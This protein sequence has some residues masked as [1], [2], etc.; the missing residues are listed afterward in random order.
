MDQFKRL[1]DG[2]WSSD[3]AKRAQAVANFGQELNSRDD[4]NALPD[5][6]TVCTDFVRK[7]HNARGAPMFTVETHAFKEGNSRAGEVM[8]Q[9]WRQCP[10]GPML[11]FKQ[12]M[13]EPPGAEP[14][15]VV[16]R[17]ADALLEDDSLL[18]LGLR[19]VRVEAVLKKKF[20][21]H[22]ENNG[23]TIE[24]FEY[25]SPTGNA[26]KAQKKVC[27]FCSQPVGPHG[28]NNPRPAAKFGSC[29]DMCNVMRVVSARF[30]ELVEQQGD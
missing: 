27:C 30:A 24:A 7:H 9:F 1:T 22:L 17:V 15:G 29:C 11:L 5:L 23:W 10:Y 3:P 4:L 12:V 19:L 6:L 26:D 16:T 25:G 18:A 28:G 20:L 13:L 8:L 2:Y 21:H 14:K